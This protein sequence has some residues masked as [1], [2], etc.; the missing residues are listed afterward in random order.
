[1]VF[2]GCKDS[3]R[4]RRR[5]K[6]R[7][8][9]GEAE[10]TVEVGGEVEKLPP[11]SAWF[12]WKTCLVSVQE[13]L[14]MGPDAQSRAEGKCKHGNRVNCCLK[15]VERWVWQRDQYKLTDGEGKDSQWPRYHPFLAWF[16]HW[17]QWLILSLWW[18]FMSHRLCFP[19]FF[20]PLSGQH[21]MLDVFELLC[22][23][24]HEC[25]ACSLE[26]SELFHQ[27]KHI[28]LTVSLSQGSWRYRRKQ[29][30]AK[31]LSQIC[32][33]HAELDWWLLVLL[34]VTPI[35]LHAMVLSSYN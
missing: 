17:H 2:L 11:G 19:F 35:P 15:A 5:R 13:G 7:T 20:S 9:V 14:T 33:L 29:H 16:L 24:H 10:C 25:L 4:R 8:W 21:R 23:G 28:L 3:F 12:S 31:T 6:R 18:Q 32:F 34:L 1:M 30:W 26:I 22:M 27:V